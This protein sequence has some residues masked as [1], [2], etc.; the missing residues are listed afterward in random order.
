MS[1][2]KHKQ[3]VIYKMNQEMDLIYFGYE[4]NAPELQ[5][6]FISELTKDFPNVKLEDAYDSIKGYRQQIMFESKDEEEINMWLIAKGWFN[7][8]LTLGILL[9]DDTRKKE[10]KRLISNTKKRYPQDFKK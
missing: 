3:K 5:N 4:N 9:L 10:V 6:Q 2:W 7:C 1:G 8:S